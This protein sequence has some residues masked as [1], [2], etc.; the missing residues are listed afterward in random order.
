VYAV[1]AAGSGLLAGRA[2]AADL[3]R[4]GRLITQRAGG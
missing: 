1:A 4:A 3:R 2:I